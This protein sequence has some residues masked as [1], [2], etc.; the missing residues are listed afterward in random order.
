MISKRKEETLDPENWDEMKAL[1]HRMLDDLMEYLKTIRDQPYIPPTDEA[2]KAIIVPLPRKGDGEEKV[3]EVFRKYIAP[4][5]MKMI[6]PDFWGFVVGTGSPY[7]TLTDMAISGI[8]VGSIFI[9]YITKQSIN[10]IKEL[11]DYPE[12]AGGVFVNGGSEA[13]FTGIAVA[14]NAK[15]QV[16]M[17]VEG[18]QGVP[19]KMTLYCSEETHDYLDRSVELLG[20]L[21]GLHPET[22]ENLIITMSP[23]LSENLNEFF[24]IAPNTSEAFISKHL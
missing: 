8:N 15:A 1:G 20:Q 21:R 16:D 7:G 19:K 13:N 5:S 3:Y 14:R 9:T 17:K 12:E 10:W 2:E 23:W 4:H 18:M 24:I 11:L 6:R 22:H